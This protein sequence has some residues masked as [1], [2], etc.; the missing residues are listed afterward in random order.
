M[1]YYVRINFIDETISETTRRLKIMIIGFRD[2]DQ[3]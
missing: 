1:I 3:F 2:I